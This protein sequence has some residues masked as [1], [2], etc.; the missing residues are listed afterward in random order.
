MADTSPGGERLPL[1][2]LLSQLLVA[3]TIEFD[4]EFEHRMPHRTTRHGSA[5]GAPDGSGRAPWLVS[6]AMWTHCMRYLPQDGLP[7]RDLARLAMLTPRGARLMLT[8]MSSW[9]G[10]LTVRPDP[11]DTRARPP[12]ADLLVCPTSAGRQA[13]RI[14]EPL[15]G[16]IEGRW[17]DRFGEDETGALRG[18]LDGVVAQ[19]DPGLPDFLPVFELAPGRARQQP[20]GDGRQLPLPALLSKV[21]LALALD[22]ERES[23]L[24]LGQYTADGASRLAISASVLR[25]LGPGP[26]RVS[27]V[28]ALTGVAKMTT[29]NWIGSLGQHGYLGTG[30]DPAAP[31][32]RAAWLTPRGE[33]ARELYI[34]WSEAIESQFSQ[35]NPAGPVAALVKSAGRLVSGKSGQSPL[36]AGI[37]PYPGG[38]RAQ[39][40]RPATLPHYPVLSHRGGFPDGS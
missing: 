7:A 33:A 38:W 3:F 35:R 9:W 2:A 14:W 28:P 29:D 16:E 32:Q 5:P 20:A 39:V 25:V 21:L 13:Q 30:P 27:A 1:P 26:V 19:L 40:P 31:R 18:A 34:R 37:E 24:S 22:F 6:M 15:A 4:N 23:G 10:Y 17:R 12:A 36:W 8:R 11:A